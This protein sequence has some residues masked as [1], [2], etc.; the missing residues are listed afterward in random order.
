MTMPTD[1]N[2]PEISAAEG[3][4]TQEY[5]YMRI[6]NAIMLGAIPPGTNLTIRG[7]AGYLDLSPTP[8]RE[9]IRRLSSEHAV[10]V[11]GNRRL[12]IPQ[13]KAGRFDELILLRIALETHA[14]E[15]ALPYISGVIIDELASLDKQMDEAIED[16]RMEDLTQLN[17]DFHRRL[18]MAN[19]DQ[20]V[21]P[22][23]E[24]IWLQLGPFQRQVVREVKTYYSVDRHKE[25][26]DALGN[27]DSMALVVAIENDIRD[28]I[29]RSGREALQREAQASTAA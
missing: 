20:Q 23:I 7:L 26:L 8:V 16:H 4:T 12:T 1:L 24:S 6:R 25:V 10:E 11:M 5:A 19:P 17:H 9:A 21:V 27:R 14:A 13:M 28:G 18:Y 15:R 29:V 2:L 3:M 22:L